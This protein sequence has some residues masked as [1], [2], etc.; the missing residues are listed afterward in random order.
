MLAGRSLTRGVFRVGSRLV[1]LARALGVVA[2]ALTPAAAPAMLGGSA[3][4]ADDVTTWTSSPGQGPRGTVIPFASGADGGCFWRVPI[5]VENFKDF[6]GTAVQIALRRLGV[7]IPLG[8]ATV[9]SDTT[10]HG[11][12]TIPA[13]LNAPPA[14]YD[15]IARCIIDNP[16][17]PG[18][19]SFEY[20]PRSFTIT[21]PPPP[22]PPPRPPPPPPSPAPSTHDP[23][24][25]PGTGAP[26]VQVLGA[27]VD[28]RSGLTT[29]TGGT[30]AVTGVPNDVLAAVGGLALALGAIAVGWG[31]ADRRA[32]RPGDVLAG[33]VPPS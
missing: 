31:R 7:T 22:P 1:F 8:E 28:R 16:D 6:T 14:V 18:V 2:L 3:A 9:A 5:D 33:L 29:V 25:L 20:D 27:V 30:L 19:R 4:G 21:A 13:D 23:A 11:A 10:W 26:S 12:V 15:L 17:L 32:R 24:A